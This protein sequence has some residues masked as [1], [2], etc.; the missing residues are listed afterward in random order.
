MGLAINRI[1][2]IS[3]PPEKAI[4][5][6]LSK[7]AVNLAI[8]ARVVHN[9][10]LRLIT[11]PVTT[12][13]ITDVHPPRVKLLIIECEVRTNI[14]CKRT[15]DNVVL[16]IDIQNCSPHL[17]EVDRTA[18]PAI[19]IILRTAAHNLVALN[20]DAPIPFLIE[21]K[22][23]AGENSIQA[24][25]GTLEITSD[26]VVFCLVANTAKETDATGTPT[27][28][29]RVV[30]KL[31]VLGNPGPRFILLRILGSRLCLARP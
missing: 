30:S 1:H 16:H 21:V 10:M 13:V 7:T 22:V 14:F 19:V 26:Q 3:V 17:L 9:Q 24:N 18:V 20:T 31:V 6:I 27:E 23:M 15:N 25:T 8:D 4:I 28:L 11:I 2:P 12:W 29:D 5:R